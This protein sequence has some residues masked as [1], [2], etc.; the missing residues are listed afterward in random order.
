MDNTQTQI[1]SALTPDVMNFHGESYAVVNL[2]QATNPQNKWNVGL[3]KD[4]KSGAK[5][6]RFVQKI[7]KWRVDIKVN[8]VQ[9]YLGAFSSY[10]DACKAAQQFRSEHHG[11][12]A[13]H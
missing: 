4:N 3:R 13:K 10:E 7:G 12:F 5:G 1:P 8:G 9:K 11:E 6:V 2:R